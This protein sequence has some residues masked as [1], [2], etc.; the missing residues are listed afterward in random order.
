[1]NDDINFMIENIQSRFKLVK[2][3]A[4]VILTAGK[5]LHYSGNLIKSSMFLYQ[6]T[7][8]K[9]YS[10]EKFLEGI[11]GDYPEHDFLVQKSFDPFS[12]DAIVR[13]QLEA[14]SWFN[15]LFRQHKGEE[16]ELLNRLWMLAGI[17]RSLSFPLTNESR[18]DYL[19]NSQKE[20]IYR[21]NESQIYI[22]M[23]NKQK[24]LVDDA[25]K[26]KEYKFKFANGCIKK[27]HWQ[28]MFTSVGLDKD[29]LN[30]AYSRLSATAHPS[31]FA[32]EQFDT[33]YNMDKHRVMTY[34]GLNL[35]SEII[36]F[37]ISDYCWCYFFCTEKFKTLSLEKQNTINKINIDLRGPE[38][39]ITKNN[40]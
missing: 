36:S 1:M 29:Y 25:I 15:N 38:F 32:I 24:K 19:T 16:Q 4:M 13:S 8:L 5:D 9:S 11:T 28:D 33:L 34:Y 6:M 21:I 17:K 20:L 26:N 22:K 3:A 40:S 14:Y 10:L 18:I 12:L 23:D 35:S 31:Y 39:A 2:D 30:H 7:V 27:T 37:L